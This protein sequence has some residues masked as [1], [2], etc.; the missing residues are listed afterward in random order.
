MG[1]G[2]APA[3]TRPP[4][5]SSRSSQIRRVNWQR[6]QTV[7]KLRYDPRADTWSGRFKFYVFDPEGFQED[8]RSFFERVAVWSVERRLPLSKRKTARLPAGEVEILARTSGD[9]ARAH[10]GALVVVRGK[11]G[12]VSVLLNTCIPSPRLRAK[13][14]NSSVILSWPCPSTGFLLESSSNLLLPNWQAAGE[15]AVTNGGAFQVS[16]SLTNPVQRYFRLRKP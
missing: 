6:Q 2:S 12:T 15:A 1:I 16:L 14:T 8:L 9:L 10:I 3:Q 13:H 4:I 7:G 11:D 5:R